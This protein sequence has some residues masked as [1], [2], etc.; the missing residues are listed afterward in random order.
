MDTKEKKKLISK[1]FKDKKIFLKE[2]RINEI[3]Q[4]Q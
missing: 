3:I 2:V 4:K 1:S